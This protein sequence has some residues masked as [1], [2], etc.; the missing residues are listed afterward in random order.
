M[1]CFK[2]DCRAIRATRVLLYSLVIL[3][4]LI[5][6]WDVG[7]LYCDDGVYSRLTAMKKFPHSEFINVWMLAG[8]RVFGYAMFLVTIA[9]AAAGIWG[10]SH[11]RLIGWFL[12]FVVTGLQCRVPFA[13]DG[14]DGFMRVALVWLAWLPYDRNGSARSGASA[15]YMIQLV[16]IYV[17]S[18]WHKSGASWMDGSALK[19]TLQAEHISSSFGLWLSQFDLLCQALTFGTLLLEGSIVALVLL[20][21][22]NEKWLMWIRLVVPGT[23]IL[24][25]LGI[26][27]TMN[28][29]LFPWIAM[30]CW[31]ALFP[32][33]LWDW[34]EQRLNRELGHLDVI[35]VDWKVSL[36]AVGCLSVVVA[37]NA[38]AHSKRVGDLHPALTWFA[39]STRLSQQWHFF[40]PRPYN[41]SDRERLVAYTSDG[42]WIDIY[43]RRGYRFEKTVRKQLKKKDRGRFFLRK[44]V[45]WH[46][47]KTGD[48]IAY[49]VLE[50]G[51]KKTGSGQD[52]R[53]RRRAW[54]GSAP[55]RIV[56]E[57]PVAK[58]LNSL[59]DLGRDWF[60]PEFV[61]L[62]TLPDLRGPIVERHLAF[63]RIGVPYEQEKMT[64]RDEIGL[65]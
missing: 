35:A 41:G 17:F 28:I 48:E 12:W 7:A 54:I 57:R 19:V 53:W 15:A 18:F 11:Q 44:F 32:S 65:Y 4:C 38:A 1:D 47:Q 42:R 63:H 36:A 40:S 16:L 22:A 49:A 2:L 27:A 8:S 59:V 64:D 30:A 51:F 58:A 34:I 5:R 29:H 50:T 45:S 23:M 56:D 9:A 52:Y 37:W 39:R 46:E 26:A 25:H 31:V 24:F 10:R 43:P 33:S 14:G 20:P 55:R 62:E 3:D 60:D 6:I 13:C 21:I 61:Y